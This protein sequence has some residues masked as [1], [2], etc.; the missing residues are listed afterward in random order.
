MAEN[1]TDRQRI[2]TFSEAAAFLRFSKSHLS[3]VLNS[4][5]RGIPPMPNIRVGR[6]VLFRRESLEQW[7]SNM[8]G[9]QAIIPGGA[10]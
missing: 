8:E 9:R 4:K 7:L 1:H 5:V 6:R 2:L 10:R 3:N